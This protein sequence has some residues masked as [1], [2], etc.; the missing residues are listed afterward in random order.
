VAQTRVYGSSSGGLGTRDAAW[1]TTV[2]LGNWNPSC[3]SLVFDIQ[4]GNDGCVVG[5]SAGGAEHFMTYAIPDSAIPDNA[6]VT[7]AQW[8]IRWQGLDDCGASHLRP[9][10]NTTQVSSSWPPQCF[11]FVTDTSRSEVVA[12]TGAVAKTDSWGFLSTVSGIPADI[13]VS[14]FAL[15]LTFTL[16]TPTATTSAA[17]EITSTTATL[18]GTINPNTATAQYP[19]SY[20]FQWGLTAAYGN[21]TTIVGG[22]TGSSNIAA[23]ANLSGLSPNTLYHF[24]VVSLNADVTTNGADMTFTASQFG[25]ELALAF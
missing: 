15:K 3:V 22:Q 7:L 25:S 2:G 13:E 20:K 4:D 18:N 11:G 16:P 9:C 24:R 1:T 5:R 8:G 10:I 6:S 12:K 21:E 14:E 19:V 17:S 23:S